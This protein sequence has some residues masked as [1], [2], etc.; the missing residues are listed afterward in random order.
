MSGLNPS[1]IDL[2]KSSKRELARILKN[3]H[4]LSKF[5]VA[6]GSG[7]VTPTFEV[8]PTLGNNFEMEW[9]EPGQQVVIHNDFP[10][11]SG[12][13]YYYI[14][15]INPATD[16]IVPLA[17]LSAG[18]TPFNHL[19][20]VV[21][22]T[23]NIGNL[24]IV[25]TATSAEPLPI[26]VKLIYIGY[27]YHGVDDIIS[28]VNIGRLI[29]LAYLIE[30]VSYVEYL[31]ENKTATITDDITNILRFTTFFGPNITKTIAEVILF[32]K[33]D[34]STLRGFAY[35]P[36]DSHNLLPSENLRI[37]WKITV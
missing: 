12:G 29:D 30:D 18:V 2:A 3:L 22:G 16:K 19:F 7:V 17:S 31:D 36:V 1:S 10:A 9:D 15:V 33:D 37:A 27:V 28:V 26:G 23:P 24:E 6:I 13:A 20:L 11:Y 5:S 32:I 34:I 14:D 21:S 25:D 8:N 35:S 4:P